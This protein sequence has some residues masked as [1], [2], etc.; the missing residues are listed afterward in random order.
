VNRKKGF[1]EDIENRRQFF[2]DVA[3]ELGFDPLVPTN[4]KKVKKTQIVKRKVAYT[5]SETCPYIE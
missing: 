1:W 5:I 4:W 3:K 2:K